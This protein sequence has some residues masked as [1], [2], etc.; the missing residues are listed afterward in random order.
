MARGKQA[1]MAAR[2]RAEAQEDVNDRL[3]D[4]LVDAKERARKYETAARRLPVVE[5]ELARVTEL[6]KGR[7]SDELV[8]ARATVQELQ[9]AL[10][11][12]TAE[13]EHLQQTHNKLAG[14]VFNL[15]EASGL[16]PTEAIEKGARMLG[17]SFTFAGVDNAE[18]LM[19]IDRQFGSAAVRRIQ[20]ARGARS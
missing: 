6:A 7:S 13:K 20:R 2:R 16:T 14:V 17:H 19:K 3:T 18:G 15:L 4:R 9:T 1:A 10:R 5:K 8:A 12:V 11:D